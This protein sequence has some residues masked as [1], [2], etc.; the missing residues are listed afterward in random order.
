YGAPVQIGLPMAKQMDHAS[1]LNTNGCHLLGK[2]VKQMTLDLPDLPTLQQYVNREPLE[3]A[4]EERG[5]YLITYQNNIL[6]YGV[7]DRGQ[8]KSQFP[9]GDWPFDLLGS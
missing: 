6:G 9:K 8:L 4:V 2:H 7:A 1:K 3:I 5:Q